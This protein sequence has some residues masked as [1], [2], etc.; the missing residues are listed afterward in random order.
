VTQEC[1]GIYIEWH[2]S[3]KEIE[4]KTYEAVQAVC[5][6]NAAEKTAADLF[7]GREQRAEQKA[8]GRQ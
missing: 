4:K 1:S 2:G 5:S 7:P 3:A 8:G 6:R